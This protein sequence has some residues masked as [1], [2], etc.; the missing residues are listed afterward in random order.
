[1]ADAALESIGSSTRKRLPAKRIGTIAVVVIVLGVVGWR[2]D[3][4]ATHALQATLARSLD[5][6]LHANETAIGTWRDS[7]LD[8]VETV[9]DRPD[10]SRAAAALRDGDRN[11]AGRLKTALSACARGDRRGYVL[12]GA[13]GDILATDRTD[14]QRGSPLQVRENTVFEEARRSGEPRMA[15]GAGVLDTPLLVSVAPVRSGPGVVAVLGVFIDPAE[16]LSRIL[17]A[18][19]IGESGVSFAFNADGVL[20]TTLPDVD[21]L[22]SLGLVEQGSSGIMRLRLADPGSDLT[23][24]HRPNAP[25]PTWPLTVGVAQALERG[26]GHD[27]EGFR[28]HRG[29]KVVG[30]W[31]FDSEQGVGFATQVDKREAY[32]PLRPL[33]NA[34]YTLFGLLVL[35]AVGGIVAFMFF[36]RLRKRVRQLGQYTLESKIGEGGMGSVYRASH[37][38]LRRPTAVKL[39]KPQAIDNESVKR[40]E[41]EVQ[42][43]STLTHPS[44]I[45]IYDY[46]RTEDGI[47]YYAMEYLHGIPL[48]QLIELAGPLPPARVVHILKQVCG[49][50]AEAHEAGLLH[51]DIKPP[52]IVLCK[53]GGLHDVAKVLDFGLV[54]EIDESSLVALTIAGHVAGTP[55]Y[56]PPERLTGSREADP[57]IDVYAVGGVGFNLL[58]ATD[59]YDATDITQMAYHVINSEIPRASERLGHPVPEALE[60]LLADC[61]AKQPDQRPAS[62]RDVLRRLEAIPGMSWTE[63]D[64]RAWWQEH[65]EQI[66]ALRRGEAV[67]TAAEADTGEFETE[68]RR[69]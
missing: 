25:A 47:F 20:L 64:A 27:V 15:R 10:V 65:A 22:V 54:K 55:A 40:F 8:W 1:M 69:F 39:L 13:N 5:T 51:R 2:V 26:R 62:A 45:A 21:R 33:Q 4:H 53:Q 66:E 16:N 32:A 38:L 11:A 68:R 7:A 58:T 3:H 63:D 31:D 61:L 6:L 14:L 46:G 59:V 50:L 23:A 36:A 42:L 41:R 48:S 9:A 12:V 52:N 43:T 28:D 29:V 49:S 19:R 67:Q 44:T 17:E 56:I 60:A 37:T 30:A 34:L 35:T 24:G 18:G 57:R